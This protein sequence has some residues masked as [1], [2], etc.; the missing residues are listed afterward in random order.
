MALQHTSYPRFYGRPLPAESAAPLAAVADALVPGEGADWPSASASG[1]L[2][3]IAERVAPHEA[4]RLA[5]LLAELDGDPTA[6]LRSLERD[7]G[8]DFALLRGWV[9]KAYYAQPAVLE[10]LRRA[11][12]DYHGAPQP[13]GYDVAEYEQEP[14][15][16]RGGFVRAGE[17]RRV[18]LP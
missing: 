3:W 11:G 2:G 13:W 6:W 8:A 4:E 18:R 16:R 1:A 14:A 12:S 9:Y 17:V 7:R 10:A 5:A 15:V